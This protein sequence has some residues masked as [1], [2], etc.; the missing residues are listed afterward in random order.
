MHKKLANCCVAKPR[1]VKCGIQFFQNNKIPEYVCLKM[2]DANS[3]MFQV[4]PKCHVSKN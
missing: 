3:S 4:K 1:L 2:A